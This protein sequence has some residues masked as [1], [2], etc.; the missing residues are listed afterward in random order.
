MGDEAVTLVS[1]PRLNRKCI[2]SRP[3]GSERVRAVCPSVLLLALKSWSNEQGT[4]G[5][6]KKGE[7]E[8]VSESG[9]GQI[10]VNRSGWPEGASLGTE[11][12]H[13]ARKALG[14]HSQAWWERKSH[15]K[16]QVLHGKRPLGGERR[17]RLRCGDRAGVGCDS[18]NSQQGSLRNAPGDSCSL[19]GQASLHL[20]R[21]QREKTETMEAGATGW[22]RGILHSQP[23][24]LTCL[25]NGEKYCPETPSDLPRATQYLQV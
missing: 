25:Y 15:G 13:F 16:S 12:R 6:R 3:L 21:A 11:R 22:G 4:H 23:L 14:R 9:L 7:V 8:A 1:S 20:S 17:W 24:L 19:R 18:R 10:L 2:M 5:P